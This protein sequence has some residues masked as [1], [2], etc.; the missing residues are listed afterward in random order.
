MESTATLLQEETQVTPVP[1]PEG[2]AAIPAPKRR[3]VPAALIIWLLFLVATVLFVPFAR[4]LIE[5]GWR[6]G[7]SMRVIE[8]WRLYTL[9][10]ALVAGPLVTPALATVLVL[11]ILGGSL[12]GLW[13]AL[14]VKSDHTVARPD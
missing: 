3:L 8:I 7:R 9:D 10:L 4:V 11:V 5:A 12:L 1:A 2:E 13:L 6:N 14:S